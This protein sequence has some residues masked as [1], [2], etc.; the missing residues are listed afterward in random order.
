MLTTGGKA[1]YAPTQ[2]VLDVIH[3]W[4]DRP[5]P[6]P[7]TADVIKKIGV[8][9]SLV[10]RTVQ[11]LRLID[12]LDKSGKPTTAMQD[13]RKAGAEEYPAR[14]AEIIRAAY[15]EI[16]IYR[17]PAV[18]STEQIADAFRAF[19]PTGMR[20]RMVRLFLGLCAEAGIIQTAPRINRK[21]G[22]ST[23]KRKT[24]VKTTPAATTVRETRRD[25]VAEVAARYAGQTG[26]TGPVG[27]TGPSGPTGPTGL[28]AGADP[29]AIRGLLQT[30]PPVGSV[31]PDEKRREW[32]EAIVAV[33]N[34]IYTRPP[35]D[36]VAQ[37]K[38][39]PSSTEGR[40]G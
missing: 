6:T 16:F 32:A 23:R 33:F 35:E 11:T 34:M 3:A 18:D 9:G 17:D 30:L 36:S 37:L 14:L 19:E 31:F 21:G 13:L 10:P 24:P 29:L 12:L 15:A 5:V 39:T 8:P 26:V 4:R 1:P 25:D 38:F 22:A 40:N 28:Q 7:I 2:A 27:A 20:D